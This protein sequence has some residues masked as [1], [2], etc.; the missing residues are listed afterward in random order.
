MEWTAAEAG[1]R[2]NELITLAITE[3]PQRVRNRE[4]TVVV[5]A[6]DA[7]ERLI[8][9]GKTF[10]EFLRSGESFEGLDLE[11]D[12]SP[13]RDAEQSIEET[14]FDVMNRAGLI[15]CLK[16]ASRSPS[17]LSTNPRHMEGFGLE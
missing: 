5:I 2:L 1:T 12:R 15:G 7:Y 8:S 9:R 3:G 13:E 14:A 11:R 17:D 10:K 16:G 4:D 6:S